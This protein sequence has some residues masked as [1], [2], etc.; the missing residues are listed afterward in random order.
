MIGDII[1]GRVGMSADT[2]VFRPHDF[3]HQQW[4]GRGIKLEFPLKVTVNLPHCLAPFEAIG[5]RLALVQQ[6][7]LD[8]TILGCRLCHVEQTLIRVT[9]LINI[10]NKSINSED[11]LK[12][13][14]RLL[15][16]KK[17]AIEEYLLN[18]FFAFSK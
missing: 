11:V 4:N 12:L 16:M 17:E 6:D 3:P 18:T 14:M 9:A 7:S 13:K 1:D 2:A 10:A 5:I 15:G 8:D